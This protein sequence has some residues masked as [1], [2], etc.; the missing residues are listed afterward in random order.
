LIP[1][2]RVPP[3]G[4][5]RDS[6]PHFVAARLGEVAFLRRQFRTGL[7][8]TIARILDMSTSLCLVVVPMDSPSRHHQRPGNI[9][10]I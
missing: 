8:T 5:S 3:P 7:R 9:A 10:G 4:A 1:R 2:F 6:D